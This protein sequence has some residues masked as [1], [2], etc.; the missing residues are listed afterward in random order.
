M[1]NLKDTISESKY[2]VNRTW[3]QIEVCL[4]PALVGVKNG[5]DNG[6]GMK[7]Y[8]DWDSASNCIGALIR[9]AVDAKQAQQ[10]LEY[11]VNNY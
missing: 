10:I 6:P 1:K 8:E 2:G 7:L 5:K 11:I 4:K 3:S 9:D